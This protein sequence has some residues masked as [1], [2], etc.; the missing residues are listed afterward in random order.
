MKIASNMVL[1]MYFKCYLLVV[2]Y[3][4][5]NY[6]EKTSIAYLFK[7]TFLPHQPIQLKCQN[8]RVR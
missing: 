1:F 6:K 3:T 8:G 7:P 5:F 4:F 2:K